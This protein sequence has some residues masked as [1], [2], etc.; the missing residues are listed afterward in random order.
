MLVLALLIVAVPLVWVWMKQARGA[1]APPLGTV[2]SWSILGAGAALAL[3]FGPLPLRLVVFAALVGSL[4][5]WLRRRGGGGRGPGDDP[6]D[7]PDPDP[8]PGDHAKPRPED[9]L[10]DRDAFDLAR[11]EWERELPKRG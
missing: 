6:P 9:E 3:R 4:A 5:V 10:L 7:A 11:A 1:A 8:D 2:V